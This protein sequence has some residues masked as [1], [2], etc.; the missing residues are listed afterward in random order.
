VDSGGI[1]NFQT[2]FNLLTAVVLIPFNGLL[3][4]LSL[5]LVKPDKPVADVHPELH[6]LDEKLYISPALAVVE[7]TKAVASMGV[8][9]KKNFERGA[10]LFDDFDEKLIKEI[11]EYE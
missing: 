7:A 1:A 8:L 9:A 4:K 2:V 5:L 6:T 10:W 11:D 3:V